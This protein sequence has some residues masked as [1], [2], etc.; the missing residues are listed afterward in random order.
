MTPATEIIEWLKTFDPFEGIGIDDGGLAL[1]NESQD[2]TF[3]I[4]GIP[5]VFDKI[6]DT[7]HDWAGNKYPEMDANERMDLTNRIIKELKL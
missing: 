4:G 1:T 2:K 7:I 5:T 6:E 3:E